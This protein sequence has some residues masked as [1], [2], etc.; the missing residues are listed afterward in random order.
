MSP[1]IWLS[2]SLTDLIFKRSNG[3][4]AVSSEPTIG[5]AKQPSFKILNWCKY[6]YQHQHKSWSRILINQRQKECLLSIE[7]VDQN[8]CWKVNESVCIKFDYWKHIRMSKTAY[9][10]IWQWTE[11]YHSTPKL[12]WESGQERNRNFDRTRQ[13]HLFGHFSSDSP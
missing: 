8:P 11:Q 9:K 10:L 13:N 4:R 6:H 2:S 7:S 3:R 5:P 1:N 12:P